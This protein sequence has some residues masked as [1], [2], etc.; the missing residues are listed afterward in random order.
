MN[1]LVTALMGPITELLGRLIPD[2][3]ARAAAAEE[4]RKL[5]L[6]NQSAML[7]ASKSVM[8]ADAASEGWLTRNARP[9][10]VMWSLA[11]ITVIMVEAMTGGA[12]NVV[13]AL[14]EVPVELWNLVSIGVGGYML[15]RSGEKIARD[16]A[17]ARQPGGGTR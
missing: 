5:L 1:P 12:Q 17:Q 8:V 2:V 9:I 14:R 13:R 3:N 15:L 10:V 4:F 7:E 11:V 16:V 6:E